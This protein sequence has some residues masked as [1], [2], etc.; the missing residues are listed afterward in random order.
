VNKPIN[1]AMAA[2]L[3]LGAVTGAVL[4]SFDDPIPAHTPKSSLEEAKKVQ[5]KHKDLPAP[6]SLEEKGRT[7]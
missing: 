6:K 5:G 4:A 7:P 1:R 3:L 2:C